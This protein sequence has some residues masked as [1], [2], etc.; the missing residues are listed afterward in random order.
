[1]MGW[2]WRSWRDRPTPDM[3]N[4]TRLNTDQW[5]EAAEALNFTAEVLR[6]K[7]KA[8]KL[9]LATLETRRNIDE[10]TRQS[11]ERL[12]HDIAYFK[13]EP[14]FSAAQT[15]S[16]NNAGTCWDRFTKLNTAYRATAQ[17][18]FTLLEILIALSI[19]SILAMVAVPLY[20]DYEVRAKVSEGFSLV[21]PVK[22]MV[23]EYHETNGTWP[24][25]NAQAAVDAPASFRSDYVDK[26]SVSANAG[27]VAITITYRIPT[28]GPKNTIV[29]TA[30]AGDKTEWSCK[31]GTV[32]NK[33]R[34]AH[35]KS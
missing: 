20:L 13:T 34:P 15:L 16:H 7:M 17:R 27:G 28:L 9:E 26:I 10:A 24:A 33:F 23:V 1:M 5:M 31:Q 29:L 12:L 14:V 6:T 2:D 22:D 19:I 32:I 3:Y 8:I 4:P 25:S 11:V 35:C 30:T 18:G 21:E